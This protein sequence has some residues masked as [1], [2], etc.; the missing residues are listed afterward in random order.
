MMSDEEKRSVLDDR[1]KQKQSVPY[2][3][4]YDYI[5]DSTRSRD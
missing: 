5:E 2:K 4:L 3:S 1:E